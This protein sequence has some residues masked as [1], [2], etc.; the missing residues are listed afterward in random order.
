MITDFELGDHVIMRKPHA[1]GSNEWIIIR[2][3]AD[4]K[5]KCVNCNRIVML[6]RS[7][8]VRSAKKILRRESDD[9]KQ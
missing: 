2:V 6:D 3:G 8:F 9:Q 4:I 5:L 1:C 7:D